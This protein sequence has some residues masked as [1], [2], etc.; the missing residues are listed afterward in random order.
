MSLIS[1]TLARRDLHRKK[2]LAP[3]PNLSDKGGQKEEY[4]LAALRLEQVKKA[5]ATT[6]VV[7]V[8]GGNGRKEG[9]WRSTD[10]GT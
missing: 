9:N 5:R 6:A 10:F 2:T 7:S 8:E 3:Q 1:T 4:M